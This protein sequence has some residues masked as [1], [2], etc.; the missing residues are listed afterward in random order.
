MQQIKKQVA[1][2]SVERQGEL[3]AY[4]VHLRNQRNPQL[5]RAV[6]Q[7]LADANRQ[8]WLTP[9]EFEKRLSRN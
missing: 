7:R 1:A 3:A 8:R 2:L 4:L 6:K 9:D 5:R